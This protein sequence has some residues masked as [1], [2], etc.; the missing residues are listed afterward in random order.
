MKLDELACV[1][2]HSKPPGYY[3]LCFAVR[4]HEDKGVE[5]L[6]MSEPK[7]LPADD[8]AAIRAVH[9]PNSSQETT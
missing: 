6:A 9:Q 7:V 3:N 4:V 1:M 5:V 2:M 8:T